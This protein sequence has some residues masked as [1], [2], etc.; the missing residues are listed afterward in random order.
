MKMMAVTV[1]TRTQVVMHLLTS[2]GWIGTIVLVLHV[3]H[4]ML[5]TCFHG[6]FLKG[7]F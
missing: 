1:S 5:V 4:V 6:T 3:A 2:S 7:M